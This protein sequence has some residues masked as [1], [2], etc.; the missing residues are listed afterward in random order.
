MVAWVPLALA[1][2][3][4]LGGLLGGGSKQTTTRTISP[5]FAGIADFLKNHYMSRLQKGAPNLEPGG[6]AAINDTYRAGRQSLNNR[7]TSMGLSGSPD[8]LAT[9]HSSLEASRMGDIGRF[10]AN[11]PLLQ[12]QYEAQDLSGLMNLMNLGMGQTT[13]GGANPLGSGIENL[14]GMLG[15]L[16]G[17]GAFGGPGSSPGYQNQQR[18]G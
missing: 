8:M 6:I 10:R 7:L 2:T 18:R 15:F 1:G 11:L 9:G 3:S 13:T 12:Q 17:N 4:L 14:A 5:E 16:W